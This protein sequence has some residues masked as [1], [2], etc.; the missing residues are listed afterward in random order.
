[1]RSN[2][3]PKGHFSTLE[4]NVSK[5]GSVVFYLSM[6]IKRPF[7]MIQYQLSKQAKMRQTDGLF[8]EFCGIEPNDF[9]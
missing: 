5:V 8:K 1:M 4:W 6:L 7:R 9:D 2:P 3:R